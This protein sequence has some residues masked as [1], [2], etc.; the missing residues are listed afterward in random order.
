MDPIHR[1]NPLRR[2]ER[3]TGGLRDM[4]QLTELPGD[5]VTQCDQLLYHVTTH[6][7]SIQMSQTWISSMTKYCLTFRSNQYY[8]RIG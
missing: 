7:N 4:L 3:S 6:S 8:P 1:I 5:T 2:Q